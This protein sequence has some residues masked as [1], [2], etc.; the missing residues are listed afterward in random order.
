MKKPSMHLF[1]GAFRFLLRHAGVSL[2]MFAFNIKRFNPPSIFFYRVK[3][4]ICSPLHRM[5]LSGQIG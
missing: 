1:N 5:N 2:R 4:I 3:L